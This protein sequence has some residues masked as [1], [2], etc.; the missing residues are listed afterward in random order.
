VSVKKLFMSLSGILVGLGL[1]LSLLGPLMVS[2]RI[3]HPMRMV[4]VT[5]RRST[6]C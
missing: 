2:R 1:R 3:F 4:F 6:S 5:M